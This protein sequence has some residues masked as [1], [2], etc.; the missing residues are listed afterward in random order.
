VIEAQHAEIEVLR[1]A[2]EASAEVIRRLELRLAEVERP[3]L[4]APVRTCG[5]LRRLP[6]YFFGEAGKDRA[7]VPPELA[8]APDDDE[9]RGLTL[10]A[11]GLSERALRAIR[12]MIEN[13]RVL[14]GPRRRRPDPA[15]HLRITRRERVSSA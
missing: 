6:L 4:A 5:L 14:E 15:R 11:A 1:A 8:V 9:L 13:A 12:D 2:Q 7:S 10:R 3:G